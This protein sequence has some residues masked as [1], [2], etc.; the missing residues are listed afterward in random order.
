MAVS[1]TRGPLTA[2][3]VLRRR[4]SEHRGSFP[5]LPVLREGA[6][7]HGAPFSAASVLGGRD[8]EHR[9]QRSIWEGRV[10]PIPAGQ[11][12]GYGLPDGYQRCSRSEGLWPK[13]LLPLEKEGAANQHCIPFYI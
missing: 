2:T 1:S 6:F 7:E 9:W 11:A 3:Y 4:D 13:G 10:N 8:S 12:V 5:G